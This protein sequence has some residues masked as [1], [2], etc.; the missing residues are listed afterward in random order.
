MLIY[1]EGEDESYKPALQRAKKEFANSEP[2]EI[3]ERTGLEYEKNKQRFTIN[4]FNQPYSVYYP[5]GDIDDSRAE[6]PV[7]RGM[8]I[9][10]LHYLLNGNDCPPSGKLMTMK[11]LPD[12]APYAGPFHR[13]AIKPLEEI[14]GK[15][16]SALKKAADELGAEFTDRADLSFELFPLP[17]VPI[18]YLL[19]QGDEEVTGGANLVFDSSIIIKLH[20]EDIAVIGE[21]TTSLLLKKAEENMV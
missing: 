1:N 7:N 10:F 19:W 2:E 15:D 18:I 16:P 12:G 9:I 20:T 8:E 21:Y 5:G 6:I 4:S 11:E 3:A 13:Q 14:M 17:R